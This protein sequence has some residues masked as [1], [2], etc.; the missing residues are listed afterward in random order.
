MSRIIRICVWKSINQPEKFM[1]GMVPL[2]QI[3]SRGP[4]IGLAVTLV[5]GDVFSTN[6]WGVDRV[7]FM[8]FWVKQKPHK[9]NE[10][11]HV[12]SEKSL[13]FA[14]SL[15]KTG[16]IFRFPIDS[17]APWTYFLSIGYVQNPQAL[18][19]MTRWEK[20]HVPSGYVKIAIEND[21]WNSGFS[22]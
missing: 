17:G 3:E 11:G 8:V 18:W 1:L 6:I 15:P 2:T 10:T 19:K 4:A 14:D 5:P 7:F 21:H 16:G 20:F 13:W 12:S 22:H 9:K